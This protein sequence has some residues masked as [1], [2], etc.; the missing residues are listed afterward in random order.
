MSLVMLRDLYQ[1]HFWANAQ[2]WRCI[3]A[4]SDEQ[5]HQEH[6]YSIGS[7]FKQ[8]FHMNLWE[9]YWFQSML[10][11]ER[12]PQEAMLDPAECADRDALRACSQATEALE[13]RVLADLIE[14][15]LAHY[16]T[17]TLTMWQILVQMYGHG[18]DHRAQ[19]LAA[20]HQMGAPT[21]EQSYMFYLKWR[22][23]NA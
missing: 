1:H 3:D 14:E 23:Q 19:A 21:V 12:L 5:L 2:L 15:D 16:L 4:I 20:L 13:R 9:Q 17:P 7:V 11:G 22:R 6:D 10:A 18:I 8:V